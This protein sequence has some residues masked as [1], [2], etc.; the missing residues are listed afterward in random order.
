MLKSGRIFVFKAGCES[1]VSP[2]SADHKSR[3]ITVGKDLP[4]K[5]LAVSGQSSSWAIPVMNA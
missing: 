1:G 3:D 5:E 2:N 4:T